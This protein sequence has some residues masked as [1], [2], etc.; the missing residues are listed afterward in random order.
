MKI[1]RRCSYMM[2][3]DELIMQGLNKTWARIMCKE[4]NKNNP[5]RMVF[6]Q[7][8]SDD[9]QLKVRDKE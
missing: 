8:V 7:M 1:V 3:D 4:M 9:F 6:Y 5:D 2:K